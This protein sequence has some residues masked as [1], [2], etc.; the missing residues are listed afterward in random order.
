MS[1]LF[2]AVA[3]LVAVAGAAQAQPYYVR[4][5]FNG[6]PGTG[7]VLMTDM[8]GGM[9]QGTVTGLTPN[10][11]VE[12]KATV[13]NWSF[14]APSAP[15]S[16]GAFGNNFWQY[17]G[18]TGS[19]TVNMFPN[20]SWS[21]GYYP[22]NTNR[23]GFVDPLVHGWEIMGDFNGSGF[24]SP[25]VSLTN[26]GNGVY[27]GTL[28]STPG[29]YQFKFRKTGDWDIAIGETFE[30]NGGNAFATINPG[31]TGVQFTLDL[32]NGRWQAVSIPTPGALALLGLGG[33]A[34]A[35]RRRA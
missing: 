35:R 6:W 15:G 19:I 25:L 17:A 3:A 18:A 22:N 5:P 1:K 2:V 4:G 11:Q 29:S 8:G 23:I 31:D 34:A 14:A 27:T 30:R 28:A 21:D 16:N 24:S 7:G 26:Q 12:L 20:T 10:A 13:E 32:P 33:L 9:H